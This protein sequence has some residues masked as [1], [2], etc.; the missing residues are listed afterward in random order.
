MAS[1]TRTELVLGMVLLLGS[2][3]ALADSVTAR[4]K[5]AALAG[6][7]AFDTND[8]TTAIERYEE[9]YR[10]KPA[11][12]LLFNLA[13]SHR[14]AGHLDD[15][16]SYFRRYLET[17]PS[18]AHADA[19]EKLIAQ[20]EAERDAQRLEQQRRA[21][22]EKEKAERAE[23]ERREKEEAARLLQIEN[24]KLASKQAEAAAATRQ[25][26]L[27]RALKEKE[28]AKAPPPIHQRWW[29]WGAIGVVVAGAVTTS[30]AVATAPQPAPTT[31]PDINAR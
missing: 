25:L 8:F 3:A 17:N 13:Q 2:T 5:A 29:F 9:A 10:L 7:K 19:V 18:K 26:E 23:K 16:I 12:A 27:E 30:V 11:P 21:L 6:K 4:A 31:F 20:V 15:A 24:A 28:L 1:S 22:E 14:R